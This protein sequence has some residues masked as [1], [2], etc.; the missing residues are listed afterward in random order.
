MTY[1]E[2]TK[3]RMT[4]LNA[5]EPKSHRLHAATVRRG[6][7]AFGMPAAGGEPSAPGGAAGGLGAA[8]G[9]GP[10]PFVTREP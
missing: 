8:P 2:K 6:A 9:S 5:L 7:G 4:V 1:T 10:D 3:D